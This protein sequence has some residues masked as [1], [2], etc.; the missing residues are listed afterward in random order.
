MFDHSSYDF[1]SLDRKT[2]SLIFSLNELHTMKLHENS[3]A[4][5]KET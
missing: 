3:A 1:F 2:Y 5:L 4:I